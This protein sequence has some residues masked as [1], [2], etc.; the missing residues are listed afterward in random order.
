MRTNTIVGAAVGGVAVGAG[1][2][3]GLGDGT[4]D[5]EGS[6]SSRVGL[7]A[8]VWVAAC[9]RIAVAVAVC[10]GEKLSTVVGSD[11]ELSSSHAT[12]NTMAMR[13][14]KMTVVGW[15]I[16]LRLLFGTLATPC[17]FP[18]PSSIQFGPG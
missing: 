10:C 7:G 16:F 2:G 18:D 17:P 13:E 9:T 4:G 11:A 6:T 12:A 1:V 5:G 8:A 14:A 3:T 15:T